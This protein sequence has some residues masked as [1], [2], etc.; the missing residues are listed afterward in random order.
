MPLLIPMKMTASHPPVLKRGQAPK[1][2]SPAASRERNPTEASM[3]QA[4]TGRVGY[5]RK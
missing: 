2:P 5:F 3:A 1:N 4:L